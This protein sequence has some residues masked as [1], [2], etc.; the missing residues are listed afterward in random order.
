MKKKLAGKFNKFSGKY[1]PEKSVS[2]SPSEKNIELFRQ[3]QLKLDRISTGNEEEL[4]FKM[5]TIAIRFNRTGEKI[6]MDLDY[7]DAMAALESVF[8]EDDANLMLK[9]L[10]E[11]AKE[12]G[13]TEDMD[14]EEIELEQENF[15]YT[16]ESFESLLVRI[17]EENDSLTAEQK[18]YFLNKIAGGMRSW[19]IEKNNNRPKEVHR[20]EVW[21]IESPIS[22]GSETNG[23]RWCI[24]ISNE[25]H[26]K[27]SWVVNVVYLDGE[28]PKNRLSHMEV[29]NAD[30]E[31]GVYKK[32]GRINITDIFTVDKKKLIERKGKVSDAF[33]E[34]LMKRIAFQLG[35]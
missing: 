8:N 18:S 13:Y 26:A 10:E 9:A 25:K 32:Q 28:K 29:K 6:E 12:F 35:I 22:V 21:K 7:P 30:L 1:E 16:K 2:H 5:A 24:I 4:A 15:W 27:C 19:E 34:K 17:K 20:G 11:L 3:A 14:S 31:D 33:M 23:Y